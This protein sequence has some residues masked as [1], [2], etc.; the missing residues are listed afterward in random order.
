MPTLPLLSVGLLIIEY[1]HSEENI[2]ILAA[3]VAAEATEEDDESAAFAIVAS[4]G[5]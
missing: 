3:A 1:K 2:P 5:N 4:S